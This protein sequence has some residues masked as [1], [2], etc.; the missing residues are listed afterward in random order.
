MMKKSAEKKMKIGS[1]QKLEIK[2]GTAAD[3]SSS[4]FSVFEVQKIALLDL[5][6][7]NDDRND[8]NII[9]RRLK[10]KRIKLTPIDHGLSLPDTLELSNSNLCW[11]AWKQ[12]KEP[13]EP[14]LL[15]FVERLRPV[16]DIKLL[17]QKLDIR[18]ECL[19]NLAIAE[20]FLKKCVS[21]DYNLYEIAR[22]MYRDNEDIRSD[23][24]K[25]VERS[26]FMFLTLS[27]SLPRDWFVFADIFKSPSKSKKFKP[28]AP[29]PAKQ[30]KHRKRIYSEQLDEIKTTEHKLLKT[31]KSKS[32]FDSSKTN[33]KMKDFLLAPRDLTPKKTPFR[34][35]LMN[36]SKKKPKSDLP[37]KLPSFRKS[38]SFTDIP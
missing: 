3:I 2:N 9:Y 31:I 30:A 17:S 11:Y 6:I 33:Q 20:I 21:F 18:K 7:L 22:M 25:I 8:E 26:Q 27:K 13:L 16:E 29:D 10:G 5:R 12:A 15:D 32:E 1:L 19:L 38:L 34:E 24:E 36:S 23:L 14:E 4:L 28:T 37:S 35:L